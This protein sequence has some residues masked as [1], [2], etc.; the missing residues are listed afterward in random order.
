MNIINGGPKGHS[1]FLFLTKNRWRPCGSDVPLL[2]WI[3]S[4]RYF[5]YRICEP[6][7]MS[8]KGMIMVRK[9]KNGSAYSYVQYVR[10]YS[11]NIKTKMFLSPLVCRQG[12][13]NITMLCLL[14]NQ[15][16]QRKT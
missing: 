11:K 3:R 6:L 13:L 2:L 16:R 5:Q 14:V 15:D 9:K 7:G 1:M 12:S 8:I 4:Y 10:V